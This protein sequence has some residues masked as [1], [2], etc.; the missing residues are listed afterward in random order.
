[1]SVWNVRNLFRA[2]TLKNLIQEL[3]KYKLNVA[4]VQEIWWKGNDIFDS[5]DYTV[6]YSGSN[7]R[8]TFE[9]CFLVHKKLKD[10]IMGFTGRSRVQVPMR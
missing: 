8:S 9:T 3:K 5:D 6:C 2:G 4:A 7:D 1:M 10:S